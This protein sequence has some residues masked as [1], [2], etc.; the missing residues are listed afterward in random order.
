M[1]SDEPW[2]C[3]QMGAVMSVWH[4]P[5][6]ILQHTT[7]YITFDDNSIVESIKHIFFE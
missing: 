6:D 4:M 5:V 7:V 1:P 3:V 2:S